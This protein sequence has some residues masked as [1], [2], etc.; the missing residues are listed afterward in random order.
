MSLRNDEQNTSLTDL[1]LTQQKQEPQQNTAGHHHHSSP[2]SP[3]NPSSSS[4]PSNQLPIATPNEL[5]QRQKSSLSPLNVRRLSSYAAHNEAAEIGPDDG[6]LA[7]PPPAS[8]TININTINNNNSNTNNNNNNNNNN[9]SS[10]SSLY[11]TPPLYQQ[12]LSTMTTTT[13][14]DTA[15]DDKYKLFTIYNGNDPDNEKL[16]GL[17]H[18][19]TGSLSSIITTSIASSEPDPGAAGGGG[20]G[21]SGPG[22]NGPGGGPGGAIPADACSIA[23]INGSSEEKLAL[24]RPG[25]KQEKWTTILLQVSIPFFLAGIGTIGAGIVLGRVEK[26]YV[27]KN[28]S[29]LFI[30]VPALLGLKGNLDMCLASRLSTQVNLGNMTSRSNVVRMIVGNIA[31]VQVQATVASF[32]VAMFAMSVGA[33]M[34]GSFYFENAMLLTASA[35]FTATSSCFV[36]DFVLVAVIL[37][38][39]KYRLNPDNL[40]TPLAASIGDVVSI[41]LLSFIAS[42]LYEHIK[43]HLW[44]TFIVV[45][46]YLVLLPMWVVIVLKNEYTRPVLKSGWVPV[47]SALCISGLGGLVLD[48]AVE[49]FNGF[50]VF[51]PIINGIGG[52]LVSV[53]AS[54][55]STMLHQSS[56]IGIIPPHT[57]VVEWP[58]RALFKGVPYAKTARILIAMSIPGNVLFIFVA[59][60]INM[61]ATTVT[62]VFMLSY[63]VASLV[64]VM[65]LLYIAHIIVH[66]MWKWKI[67]PDNSAIPYLTALGDLLGSSLLAVAWLFTMSVGMQYGSNMDTLNAPN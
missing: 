20:G 3:S 33:A 26:W 15:L 40:A 32:L 43:T 67:D 42:L 59:D 50:V 22:G 36:L 47:L 41:S 10:T 45:T 35:M 5:K 7:T 17:P 24:N 39:Q 11:A 46:C 51:Q 31:L 16:S 25:I 29:E 44:I 53:Q 62:W 37:F 18:S 6:V 1:D 57:K 28:V 66:A 19:T 30:L 38:S 2:S 60:Y 21:G 13:P 48:A 63:L 61:N 4:S 27:F 9:T 56:I 34:T 54:K 55:I 23:G 58:W 12:Q 52:N 65:L 64:Q 14:L 8:T 49:V